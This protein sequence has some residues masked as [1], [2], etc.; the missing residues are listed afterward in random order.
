[1]ASCTSCGSWI[2]DDQGSRLCSMCYGDPGHGKDGYYQRWI[3]EQW[4]RQEWEM[5]QLIL[6]HAHHQ[7]YCAGCASY[8]D[9]WVTFN[10]LMGKVDSSRCYVWSKRRS[11]NDA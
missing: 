11:V 9:S 7:C 2:P 1:M 10:D 4:N 6:K 5:L 8:P 3:E